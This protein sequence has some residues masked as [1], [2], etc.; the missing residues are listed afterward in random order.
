MNEDARGPSPFLLDHL[1]Q[2]TD[3]AH[4]GPILDIACGCGRN[5]LAVARHGARVLGLDRAAEKLH[6][7]AFT[8]RLE[9]V[10]MEA[11]RADLETGRM[12]PL[13]RQSCGAILVFRYLYRPLGPLLE[14]LLRPGGL[15]LYETFTL[16]Q[17]DLP[18]GPENEAFLLQLGELPRLFPALRVESF[19]EGRVDQPW[20]QHLARL[21]ARKPG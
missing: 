15:L 13:A 11:I 1:E 10:Q 8:A 21:V 3:A 9:G 17:R 18:Q 7:L 20:P 6:R 12:P 5:A 19:W 4:E 16:S 2:L 14:A